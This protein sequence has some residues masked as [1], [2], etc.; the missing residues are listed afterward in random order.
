MTD[1]YQELHDKWSIQGGGRSNFTFSCSAC[2]GPLEVK[3]VNLIDY[4]FHTSIAPC[5]KCRPPEAL[6]MLEEA[7]EIE[8]GKTAEWLRENPLCEV[9]EELS[10]KG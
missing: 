8:T 1:G 10:K 7:V 9:R 4:R 3:S 6:R 5:Q 2:G